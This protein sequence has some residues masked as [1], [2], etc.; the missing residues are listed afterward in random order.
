MIARGKLIENVKFQQITIPQAFTTSTTT[1][2]N[3]IAA[4]N[5]SYIDT[6]DFSE[7]IIE[8]NAG[9]FATGGEVEF[10]VV[11]H[12]SEQDPT[13]ASLVPGASFTTVTPSNDNAIQVISIQ[14]KDTARYLW[15]K[16]S[17]TDDINAS[18]VWGAAA[19]LGYPDTVPTA[20]TLVTADV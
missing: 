15:L 19:I 7:V 14:T 1:L 18:C 5:S 4:T 13:A 17:K 9:T 3:G 11:A 12:A 20:A 2:Y 6:K 16:S 8:L 10:T